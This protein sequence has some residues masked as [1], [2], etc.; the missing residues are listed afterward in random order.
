M[1]PLLRSNVI[2]NII[3]SGSIIFILFI[4]GF[5]VF[6]SIVSYFTSNQARTT[7]LITVISYHIDPLISSPSVTPD[8]LLTRQS[9]SQSAIFAKGMTIYIRGTGGDGL[10]IRDVASQNGLTLHVAAEGEEYTIMEGPE[11]N[12][13]F[14]WWR[15]RNNAIR[16]LIGWAVQDFMSI[17]LNGS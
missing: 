17:N 12:D 11:L 1:K 2:R 4:C 14:V 15:I 9:F 7:A 6:L 8:S 13:G 10:R 5:I 3:I 16:E